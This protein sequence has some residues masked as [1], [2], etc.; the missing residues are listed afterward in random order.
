[1][2]IKRAPR[3]SKTGNPAF[4]FVV[5]MERAG[6]GT[7]L[8]SAYHVRY[9]D[10]PLSIIFTPGANCVCD[11]QT[12]CHAIAHPAGTSAA[13]T[14]VH[15]EPK[16]FGL[17]V[18]TKPTLLEGL[19]ADDDNGVATM[20]GALI[21]I[22]GR[23]AVATVAHLNEDTMCLVTAGKRVFGT[24]P[25]ET[26]AWLLNVLA[27]EHTLGLAALAGALVIFAVDGDRGV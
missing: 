1:M 21:G 25:L 5:P 7:T 8:G 14:A 6:G 17:P 4:T 12:G 15:I 26:V 16:G 11:L 19:A 18:K 10:T 3:C 22:P 24:N 9:S 27:A 20:D 2:T 23:L 13:N